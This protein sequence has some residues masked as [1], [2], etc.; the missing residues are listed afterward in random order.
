MVTLC[1]D[2]SEHKRRAELVFFFSVY[3]AEKSTFML[4]T[5]AADFIRRLHF[6][7]RLSI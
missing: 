6:L 3:L 4:F 2:I 1:Y 5:E 7:L